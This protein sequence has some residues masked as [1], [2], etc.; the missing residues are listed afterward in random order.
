VRIDSPI[1]SQGIIQG[2][3]MK[4]VIQHAWVMPKSICNTRPTLVNIGLVCL[5]KQIK[6]KNHLIK[7]TMTIRWML[8][9]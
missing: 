7:K 4:G 9:L 8:A 3:T 6:I 5:M 1:F 2:D